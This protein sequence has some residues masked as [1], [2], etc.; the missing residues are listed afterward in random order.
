[1]TFHSLRIRNFQSLHNVSL[2][3]LPFTVIVG[4]S[5]SGKS[6]LTRAIRT[7]VSNRRGTE[8]IT[9]G[10][11]TASITATTDRGT[12]TLTR[13]RSTASSDNAYTITPADDPNASRT[14]SKLGG[15]TPEDVSR[16]LGLSAGSSSVPPVNFAG[17]FD[18]PFLLDESAAEVAR[19]LGALTNVSVIFDGARE[20]NR[21]KL[22]A[23]A[24]L[25]LRQADLDTVR[26]RIPEFKA[27]KAQDEALTRTEFLISTARTLTSRISQ[28]EDALLAVET[29]EPILADLEAQASRPIPSDSALVRALEAVRSFEKAL[30]RVPALAASV[31][32][33][34]AVYASVEQDEDR[35][36]SSY[37]DLTDSATA[38]LSAF[39]RANLDPMLTL[40]RDGGT[41]VELNHAVG[42]FLSYLEMKA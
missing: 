18:K 7:L 32:A 37:R 24:T 39:V 26:A 12:I 5:S 15:D 25:K 30:S 38:D 21:Q 23:S 1:M 41:Y 22:T 20:S 28:L 31:K 19:T 16:F 4:P 29:L 35:L 13:S 2:D 42:I 40:P 3:L 8:W 14:Y 17:Q 11:R 27:L 33:A 36:F 10:E 34:E 9:H 6:A